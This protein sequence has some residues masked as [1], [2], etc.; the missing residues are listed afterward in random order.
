MKNA[1]RVSITLLGA[2]CAAVA[3]AQDPPVHPAF[4][5]AAIRLDPNADGADVDKHPGFVRAQMTLKD[6]VAYAYNLRSF[7][8][9]GGPKWIDA[10]HYAIEAKLDQPTP[11]TTAQIRDAMQTLLAERFGLKF[12]RETK[13]AQGYALVAAKDGLK[14]MPDAESGPSGMTSTGYAR[15]NLEATRASM[16]RLAGFLANELQRPVLDQTQ[17]LGVYTFTLRWVREDLKRESEAKSEL[18]SLPT[19]LQEKLGLR[20]E[21]RK[22]NMEIIVIDNAERPSEN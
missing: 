13:E 22:T 7:Q 14:L 12:H 18:P 8:V 3:Y 1:I 19:A 20:L 6:Y 21:P 10:D 17:A 9:T 4:A 11:A 5:A 16:D 2:V 15:R